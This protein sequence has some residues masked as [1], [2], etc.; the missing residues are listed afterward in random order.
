MSTYGGIGG[1]GYCWVRSRPSILPCF[2]QGRCLCGAVAVEGS[3]SYVYMAGSNIVG[4]LVLG[5]ST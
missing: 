1:G 5:V 4:V 3:I 2:S